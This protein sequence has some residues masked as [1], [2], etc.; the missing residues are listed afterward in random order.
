MFSIFEIKDKELNLLPRPLMSLFI[1]HV[2]WIIFGLLESNWWHEITLRLNF[3][4]HL[5]IIQRNVDV[6]MIYVFVEVTIR[7]WVI[8]I[9]LVKNETTAKW[10]KQK[11]VCKNTNERY[12]NWLFWQ[13]QISYLKKC[14]SKCLYVYHVENKI[15]CW[16]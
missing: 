16:V 11:T 7:F 5:H 6:S 15:H 2:M 14:I 1:P 4:Y 13:Y 12:F 10:L 8:D 3:L 9:S